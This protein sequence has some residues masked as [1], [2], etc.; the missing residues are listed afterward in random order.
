MANAARI[1]LRSAVS[2]LIRTPS[3]AVSAV[4]CLALGIGATTAIA[5]AINRALLQPLPFRDADRLVA[6]HRTTPHS[7]PLGT[8]PESPGNYNDLAKASKT[9]EGLSAVTSGT[10]LVDGGGTGGGVQASALYITG[11]LFDM[12]GAR[13]ARGRLIVPDDDQLDH[14]TAAVVSDEFWQR[15]FGADPSVVGRKVTIDGQPTTIVGILPPRFRVPHAGRVLTADMW[16]PIRFTPE[17]LAVRRSNS[18]LLLGR[19]A[20]SATVAGADAELKSLFGHLVEA[21]PDL[22]GENVR[23]AAL[24][25]ESAQ[26]I[27]TPLYLVFGAVCLVLLIAGTNVAALLLARGLHR[28]REIAVRVAL[29]ASRW[30]AMRIAL[31]ESLAISVVGTGLGLGI[32]IVG[33]KTIGTLASSRIPLLAGLEIDAR[34][35][36]FAFVLAI[37][38]AVLCAA[39][40]AWRNATVDPNDALRGGR[41]GGAGVAHHRMLR[42]LVVGEIALSLLLLIGAGL[43]LRAFAGLMGNDPGFETQH[44]LTLDV[45]TSPARYPNQNSVRDF[46]DPAISAISAIPGVVAAGSITSM[47]Y[48]QFGNN[49]PVRYEGMPRDDPSSQPIAEYR[50]ITPSFFGVTKQRLLGG[51]LLNNTDDGS[52]NAAPVVV[53]NEALVKR[54]FKDG[55]AVGRRFYVTD[56]SFATIVGVVSDIRN[57]GPFRDPQPEMYWSYRQSEPGTATFPIMIR[58]TGD[59]ET[60]ATSVRNAIQSI[61]RTAAIANVES[62][63]SVIARSLAS[64]RFYMLLLGAF[65][66][67]ALILSLAGL[68]GMLSYAVAQRTRELGIRIALGAPHSRVLRLVVGE[69]TRLVFTGIVIGLIASFALTRLM[70]SLLYGVSPLDLEAW[71]VAIVAMIGS[72]VVAT[73]F[74]ANRAARADPVIAMRT[75]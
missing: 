11:G 67:V 25:A 50:G 56:T 38:V 20:P 13:A 30:D 70:T 35:I 14:P 19:L 44:V 24:R 12:L 43:V 5:S 46:L 75:E 42:S 55:N 73:L 66:G 28:R 72:G 9:V 36:A 17:R 23:V 3:V 54:D 45:A 51:R 31:L 16:M 37:V 47:P 29:G 6:V 32:A 41:G 57:M 62:M 63:P 33:V 65:A 7:G 53:V 61:D 69:G 34:I 60:V 1:E 26:S 64:P 40:P 18:L 71:A 22:H 59:P 2:G 15:Q 58:T 52:P 68:Y 74:P 27:K 39:V 8:W 4:L 21:Y 10:A 48:V 49:G